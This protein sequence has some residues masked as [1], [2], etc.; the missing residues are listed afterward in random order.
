MVMK[1]EK[2]KKRSIIISMVLVVLILTTGCSGYM[3]GYT[4]SRAR[5]Q[6][7][8]VDEKTENF[9][10]KRLQYIIGFRKDA[11]RNFIE[12]KGL[13]DYIY[14]YKKDDEEGHKREGFIFYYLNEGKAYDFMEK[15]WKPDSARM[16]EI[17][18]FTKFEK[19]RFGI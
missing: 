12:E 2:M 3:H 19:S 16:I 4:K 14:E 7:L 18:E 8:K 15:S 5:D 9:G 1:G 10:F 13:P 17:R 6:Y 11:I